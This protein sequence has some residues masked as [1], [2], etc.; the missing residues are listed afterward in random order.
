[1]QQ[2]TTGIDAKNEWPPP[3][4]SAAPAG[5][6]HGFREPDDLKLV[7]GG[8][9]LLLELIETP[10]FQRLKNVRFLGA[11]DYRLVP[12]PNGKPR[13]TRYTRYEHSIGVMR[14]AQ[15]YC[16]VRD[17]RPVDRRLASVAALLHDLGHPPFS[18]SMESVFKEE[19]GIDHHEATT[20]MIH[21]RIPFGREVF[22]AIRRR[23]VDIEK[24]TAVISGEV[25]EFDGFFHGPINFDTIEGILRS[26]MYVLQSSTVPD[27]YAV[28][29]AATRRA[30][31]DDRRTV[32]RFWRCKGWVYE[33]V[34]NSREGVLSDLACKLFL[35]RNLGRIDR[36]SYFGTEADLFR[37]LPGLRELLAGRG[38]EDDV[39]RM[40][41]ET[42]YYRS[43][44]FHI[45][46]E[47]D[48]FARQDDVRY[49]QSRSDR[50]L[51]LMNG[52][53]RAGGETMDRR[54][55]GGLFDDDDG[56]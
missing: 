37:K 21:G 50:A 29:E 49:R 28:T 43:R 54:R 3:G 13:A 56:L 5:A 48:F 42:A 19:F 26:C 11:I 22:E 1:M 41:D 31:E 17:L 8:D 20:D 47:G 51:A 23:G 27:R 2:R 25:P 6:M 24:L 32:D 39:V 45:D 52:S 7:T 15:S 10:A 14:L 44:H 9:P 35:R 38:F 16:D 34:V 40:I 36:G 53:S 4:G 18:H 46:P 30:D 55:Q 12:R 33:N